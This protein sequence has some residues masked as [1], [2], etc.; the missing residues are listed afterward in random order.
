MMDT[1]V[2]YWLWNEDE[3]L[4]HPRKYTAAHVNAQ[5]PLLKKHMSGSYQVVCITDDPTGLDP[6]I[7]AIEMPCDDGPVEAS[8]KRW[9]RCYRK[10]WNFS[11]DARRLGKRILSLDVD[12]FPVRSLAPIVERDEDLVVWRNKRFIMG[13]VY[14]LKTGT[15]TQI[16]HEFDFIESPRIL[17]EHGLPESDQGWLTHMVPRVTPHFGPEVYSPPLYGDTALPETAAL[18]SFGTSYKPW[19]KAAQIRHPWIAEHYEVAHA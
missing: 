2:T 3:G 12:G 11:F 18:L 17:R 4:H 14:L 6:S 15:R 16:W 13:G 10:I 1:T 19:M 5:L 8:D 9:P 7:N